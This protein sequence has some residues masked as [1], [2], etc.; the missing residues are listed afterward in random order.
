MFSRRFFARCDRWQERWDAF[1]TSRKEKEEEM[2]TELTGQ[3]EKLKTLLKEKNNEL[4]CVRS[5]NGYI[6]DQ[7]N[8]AQGQIEELKVLAGLKK[9]RL[10]E[11]FGEDDGNYYREH[12]NELDGVIHQ[13]NLLIRRLIEFPDHPDTIALLAEVRSS[14]YG[15]LWRSSFD[16]FSAK[17]PFLELICMKTFSLLHLDLRSLSMARSSRETGIKR[18]SPRCS[19]SI[20]C[21]TSRIADSG[22]HRYGTRRNQQKVMEGLQ[23]ELAEM[24]VR[25]NQF[26]DVVQG[27]AQGQQE[28]RQMIQRNPATTQP[29]VVTDPPNAEVNGP[30]PVPIPHNNL[31]QQ[32]LHDDQDDQFLLPEDFGMGHGMDPMF[33][34]LEERLKAV[35][36]QNPLGVDVS[37]LGL[38]PEKRLKSGK[39][40]RAKS[41]RTRVE[42]RKSSKLKDCRIN[43]DDMDEYC[44]KIGLGKVELERSRSRENHSRSGNLVSGHTRMAL[45]NTRMRWSGT[46][47]A[48]GNTRMDEEDVV[49]NVVWSLLFLV[50]QLRNVI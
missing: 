7:L 5:T 3:M 29:E 14:P 11:L 20:W 28:I 50:V 46:R 30:G 38:V 41:Q 43:S 10:E 22:I 12:I 16:V 49:L 21:S 33:R 19:H 45:G 47:M 9:S 42:E 27:V 15:L 1:S 39:G 23:A 17:A 6:T 2:V 24:R 44:V 8:E 36:G 25:M 31:D 13:R 4:L 35:E 18:V 26:M 32:P 48:L 37:D 34:R 40:K